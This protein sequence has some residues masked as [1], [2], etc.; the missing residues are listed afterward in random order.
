MR[1]VLLGTPSHDGKVEAAYA[2]C[3][4]Q[5]VLLA[6]QQDIQ[7]MPIVV[8]YDAMVQRAR[9]D[10]IKYALDG[11]CDDIVFIDSDQEWEP[12]WVLRLLSHE[13]DVVGGAVVKKSDTHLAFNV[14]AFKDGLTVEDNGLAKVECIGTGFLRIS[15]NAMKQVWAASDTYTNEGKECRMVF[16]VKV[17]DGELVSEDNVFCHKWRDLGGN[18]FVDVTMTCAHY[19]TKRYVGNLMAFLEELKLRSEPPQEEQPATTE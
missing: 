10:L 12:Y 8:S 18:V 14:K 16:D 13:A 15:R 6:A 4:A 1:K 5:T 9:N 2:I 17:I 7:I 19:G 3:L 11:E